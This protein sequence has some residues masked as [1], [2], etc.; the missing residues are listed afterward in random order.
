MRKFTREELAQ[1]NGRDGAPAYVAYQG[2]VYDATGSWHWRDGRHQAR[3][4]AGADFNGELEGAPHGPDLL[5]R[6]PVV[7]VVVEKE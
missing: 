2:K 7:G 1:Y 6:L 3:H 4:Q 5:Q